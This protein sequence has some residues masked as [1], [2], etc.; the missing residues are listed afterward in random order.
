MYNNSNINSYI[1][2]IIL[3]WIVNINTTLYTFFKTIINYISK[4][5]FKAKLKT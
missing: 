4:Y 1:R 5:C 2:G 3:G